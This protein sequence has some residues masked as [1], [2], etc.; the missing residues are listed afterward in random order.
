M[1]LH[2]GDDGE[3]GQYGFPDDRVQE[4]TQEELQSRID[5]GGGERIPTLEQVLQLCLLSPQM[6]INIELKAPYDD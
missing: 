3:L 1:V 5:V 4:W 2:P 6:L